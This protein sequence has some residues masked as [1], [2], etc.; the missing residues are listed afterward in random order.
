MAGAG[1]GSGQDKPVLISSVH[2]VDMHVLVSVLQRSGISFQGAQDFARGNP[3]AS[4]ADRRALAS[5]FSDAL[6]Q[7]SAGRRV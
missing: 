6:R 2:P 5:M 3:V 7:L 1:V 4:S